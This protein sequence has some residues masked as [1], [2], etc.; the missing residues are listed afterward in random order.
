MWL[1]TNSNERR[2][3][4]ARRN[5]EERLLDEQTILL[6]RF[7]RGVTRVTVGIQN[8]VDVSD[9]NRDG[10]VGIQRLVERMGQVQN[11]VIAEIG[12]DHNVVYQ[13]QNI[14]RL[15]VTNAGYPQVLVQWGGYNDTYFLFI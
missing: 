13:V 11:R 6:N 5:Q 8:H 2:R 4:R 14:L 9:L 7:E 15:R 3:N 12:E 10:A 1:M